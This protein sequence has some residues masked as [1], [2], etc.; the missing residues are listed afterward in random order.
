MRQMSA[1]YLQSGVTTLLPTL[2]SAPLDDLHRAIA[3]INAVAAEEQEHPG[4]RAHFAGV[5]LEGRYLNIKK[6]GAHAPELLAPPDADELAEL[7]SKMDGARH[8]TAALELD[9]DGSFLKKALALGATV[10][11]GHTNATYHEAVDAITRGATAMT[12]LFNAMPPLHHRDGGAVCAGML[13]PTVSCELIVD[14]FH[15]APEMVALAWRMKGDHLVLITD[16]MEATGCADG[17][18]TIAGMPVT[19]RDGKARTHDGA[20]AGSTLSL[21]DGVKNLCDFAKAPFADALYA[22]TMAP[23][24]EVGLEAEVGS[25]A[26]GKRGDLLLLSSGCDA[27]AWSQIDTVICGGVPVAD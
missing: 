7:L 3:R 21:W 16:S 14:G 9:T 13:D 4:A 22:A 1:S 15:I 17:E 11:L 6:R 24:V 27:T 25:I 5:H 20:I 8:V 12:H 23:A 18:Y 2:A 10:G 26:V 19:V